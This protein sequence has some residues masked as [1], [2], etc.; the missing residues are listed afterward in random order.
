VIE[1]VTHRRCHI[2]GIGLA[3]P[4]LEVVREDKRLHAAHVGIL[5]LVT[6]TNMAGRKSAT[7]AMRG[8][9]DDC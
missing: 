7:K 3:P 4:Y 1:Q 8:Q 6:G 2:D 5:L 9:D